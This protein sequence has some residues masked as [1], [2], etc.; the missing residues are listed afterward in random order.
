MIVAITGGTGFIGRKLALRH[1]ARGDRVRV[2][3]RRADFSVLSDGIDLFKG[4]LA[5]K[6]TDLQPFVDQVDILYHCAGEITSEDSMHD[7]HVNGTA[8]LIKAAA[9]NVRH[10]VQLSSVGAYGRHLSGIIMEDTPERPVGVYETT[11]TLADNLVMEAAIPENFSY[12]VLRPSTV[13]GKDMSNQ[14]LTQWVSAIQ[15]GWFFYIGKPGAM[16]NYVHVDSV[17]DALLLCGTAVEAK[18][19][20]YIV[21]EALEIEFFVGLICEILG[22]PVPRLRVP[23]SLARA[24]GSVGKLFWSGFPLTPSRIAAL[25]NRTVYSSSRIRE[26]LDYTPSVSLEEG[27]RR[28]V[29]QWRVDGR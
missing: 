27:M 14:S 7:L 18:S 2:L 21:S 3:S 12:T 13:F 25:T 20:I 1:V 11:K 4:D 8:S 24:A 23:Q 10:W 5:K 28:F 17:V 6:G 16:V 9:G 15:R 26:M 22:R 19:R 29:G